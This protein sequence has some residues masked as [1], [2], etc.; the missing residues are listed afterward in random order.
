MRRVRQSLSD[1][2]DK[3]SQ[4]RALNGAECLMR[5]LC[6]GVN[7]ISHNCLVPTN[8]DFEKD[9][10]AFYR[11]LFKLLKTNPALKLFFN[12]TGP[13]LDFLK[14]H[15]GEAIRMLKDLSLTNQIEIL[16]NGYHNPIFP[17]L[18]P[19]E[20]TSQLE[21]FTELVR[22]TLGK[23]TRGII[24]VMS[25]WDFSV[26]PSFS[27]VPL[28]YMIL[29]E[30]VLPKPLS[31]NPYIMSDKGRTLFILPRQDFSDDMDAPRV[32]L[33][34]ADIVL[35][36]INDG[37]LQRALNKD[38]DFAFVLPCE[39]VSAAENHERIFISMCGSPT[40][41]NIYLDE[42]TAYK[43]LNDRLIYECLLLNQNRI[44][45]AAKEQAK[46]HLLCA[47]NSIT[48]LGD[49]I[50]RFDTYKELSLAESALREPSSF[51]ESMTRSDIDG[52]GIGEYIVRMRRYFCII[53][54]STGCVS[55]F[56][57][58]T[59]PSGN[60]ID[61]GFL[62]KDTIG[63]VEPQ[64][65]ETKFLFSYTKL[66]H[67]ASKPFST[68]SG[69]AVAIKKRI[70]FS[71]TSFTF[72]YIITNQSN[73][74]L[75]TSFSITHKL[76]SLP[77]YTIEAVTNTEAVLLFGDKSCQAVEGVQI[78]NDFRPASFVL[79]LNEPA[80]CEC[81]GDTTLKLS[82]PINLAPHGETE[83]TISFCILQ[84]PRKRL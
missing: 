51:K 75:I 34:S 56:E 33:E 72:Q 59:P 70:N 16:A 44:D 62:F 39:I 53:N 63:E 42:H 65:T 64:Y 54:Q 50:I 43:A 26:L 24:P 20:R 61:D 12:F 3:I 47:Q 2:R 81:F 21:L 35:K 11:P 25:M 5:S 17:L 1:G 45:K 76:A 23:R 38:A 68:K 74:P 27:K 19:K 66:L 4:Q 57:K 14:K 71:D 31:P 49:T 67:L 80:F 41:T 22:S 10:K 7:T 37:L 28:D 29:D 83:K 52:D 60:Y 78:T 58:V 36:R 30:G 8:Q 82:W 79:E 13:L 32:A 9:F 48:A 69:Q 15:H 73:D 84:T 55:E 18:F 77:A 6:L 40:P 46:A